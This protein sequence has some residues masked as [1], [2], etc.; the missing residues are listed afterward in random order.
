MG[1]Q[2]SHRGSRRGSGQRFQKS[3]HEKAKSRVHKQ[4][5]AKGIYS[6]EQTTAT[7]K[8]AAE[9]ATIMLARLGEQKFAVSPYRQYFDDWLVNVRQALSEF[10]AA[11]TVTVDESF[12]KERDQTL[13]KIEREFA[14]VKKEEET[15]EPCVKELA[16]T[17]HLL[18]ELD[19]DYAAKTRE[20]GAKRNNDVQR[21]T[22][23][24]QSLEE[25]LE[26]AKAI[27]TSFIGGVSKKAKAQKI[28]EATSNLSKAKFELE[29]T[30]QSFK[31]EQDK[32]HDRY[33]AKKQTAMARVQTLEMDIEKLETDKSQTARHYAT[34][35][36]TKAVKSLIER[37][38]QPQ[39]ETET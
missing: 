13:A 14:E 9:K 31:L 23:T 2:S 38:P 5:Q 36:L 11:Q 16:D 17:N 10:E 19:A 6:E 8:M 39:S 28:E 35:I 25:E 22:K 30:I 32:M 37:Q 27:R 33:E 18:V 26:R 20:T 34:E 24:V 15:V 12:V 29:K 7:A 1:Y 4:R 21:L 3:Q